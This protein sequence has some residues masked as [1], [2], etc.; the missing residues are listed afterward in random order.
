MY[1]RRQT[2]LGI[3]LQGGIDMDLE[4]EIEEVILSALQR[5]IASIRQASQIKGI[6]WMTFI[7]Q[8]VKYVAH[9]C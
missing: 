2:L 3:G 5:D 4:V 8:R 6:A 1:I 9:I 7:V